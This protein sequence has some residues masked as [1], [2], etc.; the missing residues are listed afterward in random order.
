MAANKSGVATKSGL[1]Y[2]AEIIDSP[3]TGEMHIGI[4][5]SS[6]QKQTIPLT[7]GKKIM[8]FIHVPIILSTP[9]EIPNDLYEAKAEDWGS[10]GSNGVGSSDNQ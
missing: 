10:R 1:L 4:F 2:T 8:Q 7:E 3:Y 6:A 5:N 9:V